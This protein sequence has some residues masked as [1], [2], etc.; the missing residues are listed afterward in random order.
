VSVFI[1]N[2]GNMM[3]SNAL[4]LRTM[5]KGT[6]RASLVGNAVR[7]TIGAEAAIFVAIRNSGNI[8]LQ[9][10]S[11][12]LE[13]RR[14]EL[15]S[16]A[17]ISKN[18]RKGCIRDACIEV[19]ITDSGNVM[20]RKG[21][22][23]GVGLTLGGTLLR[24]GIST[25]CANGGVQ[26]ANIIRSGNMYEVEGASLQ[27]S[28][29]VLPPIVSGR[30]KTTR[31]SSFVTASANVEVRS[32]ILM[33][34]S[35]LSWGLVRLSKATDL[36]IS[37]QAANLANMQASRHNR[38]ASGAVSD[39]VSVGGNTKKVIILGTAKNLGNVDAKSEVILESSAS[40]L[41]TLVRLEG[42]SFYTKVQAILS[43]S[44]NLR[45]AKKV[46]LKRSELVSNVVLASHAVHLLAK[47][48]MM[49]T[50]NTYVSGTT[51]LREGG[52]LVRAIVEVQRTTKMALVLAISEKSSNVER[53]APK[54]LSC[55]CSSAR[56]MQTAVILD[57]VD[58]GAV[59]KCA[60]KLTKV[61]NS[62]AKPTKPRTFFGHAFV[63]A[64]GA[65]KIQVEQNTVGKTL[66]SFK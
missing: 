66:Y 25:R 41:R 6:V 9:A 35:W 26:I 11:R 19:E 29:L 17:V 46:I 21:G 27:G 52:V 8:F 36:K 31:L 30:M 5:G 3:V 28:S 7:G 10:T 43:A 37:T 65:D 47:V 16:E 22:K 34:R 45:S 50:A 44:C 1:I 39:V 63:S 24:A 38:S 58:N 15:V 4:Q 12:A 2:S 62:L 42:C 23:S 60:I 13:I 54:S 53:T 64:R 33:A 51:V 40:C 20:G 32:D 18:R 49:K 61:A 55:T 59:V 48:K 57:D 56:F 14:A